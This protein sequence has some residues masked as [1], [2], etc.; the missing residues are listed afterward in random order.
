MLKPYWIIGFSLAITACGSSSTT[1]PA[2]TTDSDQ[3]ADSPPL[4]EFG[5]VLAEDEIEPDDNSANTNLAAFFGRHENP[6]TLSDV[7]S[8]YRRAVDTCVISE[9]NEGINRVDNILEGPSFNAISAGPILSFVAASGLAFLAPQ[10]T[11]GR[12]EIFYRVDPELPFPLPQGINVDI[13][14]QDFPALTALLPDAVALTGFLPASNRNST[15]ITPDTQFTW[16]A[17]TDSN[18]RILIRSDISN[19]ESTSPPV[20][21]DCE[22]INDD[23][24]CQ[25]SPL[26]FFC[27][28]QDDGFFEFPEELKTALGAGYINEGEFMAMR[29]SLTT[30]EQDGTALL[31]VRDRP[32]D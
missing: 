6:T 29:R 2:Q 30:V 8:I 23:G 24:F 22:F 10:I 20:G 14:G 9:E 32:A 31:L 19:F 11:G 15:V 1:D 3:A 25:L 13:P 5:V 16:Q 4:T 28:V 7:T 26:D 17:G 18:A 21:F 12:P 27:D